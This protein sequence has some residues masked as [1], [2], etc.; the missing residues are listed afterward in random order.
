MSNVLLIAGVV[1]VLFHAGVTAH[2]VDAGYA[3]PHILGYIL[4]S[5]GML[6]GAMRWAYQV[7]IDKGT[8]KSQALDNGI[9]RNL[10]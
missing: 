1:C 9:R 5:L 6:S 7:S 8:E 2:G 3:G 4:V 10:N